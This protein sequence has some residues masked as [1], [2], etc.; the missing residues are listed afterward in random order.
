MWTVA[1]NVWMDATLTQVH[2]ETKAKIGLVQTCLL[3]M[4]T[5]PLCKVTLYCHN[6]F[7]S[8][9]GGGGGGGVRAN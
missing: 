5:L 1:E 6:L 8:G 2:S 7:G 3:C 9:P 4:C